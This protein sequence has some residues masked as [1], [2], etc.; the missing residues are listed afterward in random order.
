MTLV[1]GRINGIA[2]IVP[3]LFRCFEF[4]FS[5]HGDA[6]MQQVMMGRVLG[7]YHGRMG[8]TSVVLLQNNRVLSHFALSFSLALLLLQNLLMSAAVGSGRVMVDGWHSLLVV[9]GAR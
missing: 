8:L 9:L 4:E 3:E 2:R 7:I 1:Q 6:T 5:F